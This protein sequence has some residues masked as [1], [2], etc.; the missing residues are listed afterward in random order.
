VGALEQLAQAGTRVEVRA[1]P[2]DKP[3]ELPEL[4]QR[5]RQGG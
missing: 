1:V 4:V 3:L 2:V 5:W